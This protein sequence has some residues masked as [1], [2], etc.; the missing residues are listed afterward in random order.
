METNTIRGYI[1]PET[2]IDVHLSITDSRISLH[3]IFEHTM[4]EGHPLLVV[5]LVVASTR[6]RYA[7]LVMV[8]QFHPGDG[9]EIRTVCNI[10]QAIVGVREVTMV[11]PHMM[12]VVESN[13]VN[14]TFLQRDIPYNDIPLAACSQRNT[15]QRLSASTA[16]NRLV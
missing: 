7:H 11:N 15:I 8:V 14:T 4:R 12:A 16:N 5:I 9:E 1:L 13:T 10:E 2:V 6:I 3:I